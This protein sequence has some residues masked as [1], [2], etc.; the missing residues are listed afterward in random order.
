[1]TMLKPK[2][3]ADLLGITDATLRTWVGD[4]EFAAFLS[5][6]ARG[7][8]GARRSYDEQDARILAW[9][10]QMRA[11]NTTRDDIVDTLRASQADRWTDLPPLPRGGAGNAQIAV[12]PREAVE[13]RFLALREQYDLQLKAVVVEKERLQAELT[14]VRGELTKSQGVNTTLQTKLTE[15]STKEA[16]LRG[17][18]AQY[19][20]G[21]RRLSAFTWMII[22]LV[23]GIVLTIVV[24][25]IVVASR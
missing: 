24:V 13:E 16:E 14:E 17:I 15:L 11:S 10:A 5:P 4:G 7:G 18:L 20:F 8:K 3:L 6:Q 1:M 9:I 21:G 19:E 23:V 25:V 22:S 12:M 2:Q